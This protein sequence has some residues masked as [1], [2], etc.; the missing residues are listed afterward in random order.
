MSQAVAGASNDDAR[1]LYCLILYLLYYIIL[2]CGGRAAPCHERTPAAA[3]AG[4]SNDYYDYNTTT[5]NAS[6]YTTTA[7][8]TIMLRISCGCVPQPDGRVARARE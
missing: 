2:Y 5:H 6:Q 4:V 7:M 3:V 1:L 8:T